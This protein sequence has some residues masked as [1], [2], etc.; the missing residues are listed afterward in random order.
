MTF[1]SAGFF[2][3]HAALPD[4]NRELPRRVNTGR[5]MPFSTIPHPQLQ[6]SLGNYPAPQ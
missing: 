6:L 2:L 3:F 5:F 1:V 4:G